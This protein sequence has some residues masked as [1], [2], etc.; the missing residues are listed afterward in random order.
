MV[1]ELALA[2][3]SFLIL[4][5]NSLAVVSPPTA[6]VH[7]K[8]L[9][10]PTGDDLGTAKVTQFKSES[11]GRDYSKRFRDNVATNIPYGLY[12]LQLYQDGFYTA[13]RQV[14]VKQPIVWVVTG[15]D[16]GGAG[17]DM[18]S[19]TV[20]GNVRNTPPTGEPVWVRLTGVHSM[21]MRDAKL[22]DSGKFLIAGLRQDK[23]VFIVWSGGQI[24]HVKPVSIPSDKPV[25]IDLA[26]RPDT[27]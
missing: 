23:A 21:L 7:L 9:I 24:L 27:H 12:R 22:D 10:A 6:E 25:T 8:I 15:L 14:V 2:L 18:R 17:D 5:T 1:R 3:V 4:F 19:F 26:E 11:D 16:I 13:E 20:T